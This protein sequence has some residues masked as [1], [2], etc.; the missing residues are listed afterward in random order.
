VPISVTGLRELPTGQPTTLVAPLVELGAALHVLGDPSHHRAE[1]WAAAVRDR[2][3]PELRRRTAAWAWTSQ[4]I[5]AA[6]YVSVTTAA[7]DFDAS[8][9]RLREVPARR[10]ATQL[11]RPI[12]RTGDLALARRWSRSR[13]PAVVA[14]IDTLIERPDVGVADFIDFL[15]ETWTH[16][17]AAEWRRVEPIVRGRLRRFSRTVA[18]SGSVAR[19]LARLDDSIAPAPSDTGVTIAKVQNRRHDVSTRG[20]AVTLSEFGWPHLYVADVPGQPLLL[21]CPASA[22]DDV[23]PTDSVAA[24][25]TRTAALAHPGRLEV[26]RAIATEPR[27]AGEIAAL[28]RMD[29]TQVNRH[30]R[31]LAAAGLARPTRRGRFV[32]YGLDLDAIRGHGDELARLLLR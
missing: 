2:L 31:S 20:L 24:V 21:I 12:A 26:A 14:R 11:L 5:R 32:Q 6:P 9:D 4:A 16:W 30:L 23:G 13:D 10:L 3:R 27:T 1:P 22:P 17:F 18:S 28:W 15:G 29:P 8:L 25:L 7:A 19:S